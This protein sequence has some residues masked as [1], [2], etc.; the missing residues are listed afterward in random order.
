MISQEQENPLQRKYPFEG[1]DIEYVRY[2]DVMSLA[3]SH[4][5]WSWVLRFRAFAA[6]CL[7]AEHRR[8]PTSAGICLSP[9]FK[10]CRLLHL[11]TSGTFHEKNSI[12]GKTMSFGVE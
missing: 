6:R 12:R 5:E 8:I 10:K 7:V 3:P 2:A 1:S 9:H 4:I 11:L